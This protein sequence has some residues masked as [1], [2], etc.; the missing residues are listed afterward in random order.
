LLA[1]IYISILHDRIPNCLSL[2]LCLQWYNAIKRDR[3]SDSVGLH[4]RPSMTVQIMC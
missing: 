2:A 4:D 1:C 3:T